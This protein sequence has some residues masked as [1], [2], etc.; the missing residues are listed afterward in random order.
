MPGKPR[1][2][3]D[4]HKIHDGYV[5][6]T[7]YL[8]PVLKHLICR[9]N[10]GRHCVIVIVSISPHFSGFAKLNVSPAQQAFDLLRK[11]NYLGAPFKEALQT[12]LL[13]SYVLQ[14]DMKPQA[15][16]V[17]QGST[18]RLALC[19]GIHKQTTQSRNTLIPPGEEKLLR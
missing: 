4:L 5:Y 6:C 7:Q 14:N 2:Y 1:K 13:L 12:L 8:Q 9:L 3:P 15:A 16:W 11:F 17:L 18:I 19:V 10:A